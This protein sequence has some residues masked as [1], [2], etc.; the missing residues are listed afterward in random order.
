M[1]PGVIVCQHL[2]CLLLAFSFKANDDCSVS[3]DLKVK[4]EQR[5]DLLTLVLAVLD[6]G[7]LDE[8]LHLMGFVAAVLPKAP[9][10]PL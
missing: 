8:R 1:G 3:A 10:A 5:A 9:S 6:Q 7:L 4:P 2:V